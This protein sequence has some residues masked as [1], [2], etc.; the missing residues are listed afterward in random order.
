[1]HSSQV[2]RFELG[3]NVACCF[4]RG[5]VIEGSEKVLLTFSF[6]GSIEFQMF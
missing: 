1:M 4:S 5:I 3:L 2:C 6:R